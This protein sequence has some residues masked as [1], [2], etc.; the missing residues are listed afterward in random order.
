MVSPEFQN[1]RAK[2]R[3]R[4]TAD[5]FDCLDLS[6][7]SS[8]LL[9]PSLQPQFDGSDDENAFPFQVSP[10]ESY[11]RT[12]VH[13]NTG[14]CAHLHSKVQTTKLKIDAASDPLSPL[15]NVESSAAQKSS[16]AVN[17]PAPLT[18]PVGQQ[19]GQHEV[20]RHP[21]F[22]SKHL[23]A[24]TAFCVS[25]LPDC[26]CILNLSKHQACCPANFTSRLAGSRSLQIH[27]GKA[28]FSSKALVLQQ[29]RLAYWK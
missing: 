20:R 8:S 16:C 3:L 28:Q 4:D 1:Y 14:S 15:T 6:I 22:L 2:L 10:T 11:S 13:N 19:V 29:L 24:C 25:S 18:P 9:S 17:L 7:Q 21:A 12:A 5:P 27:V 23:T 26:R